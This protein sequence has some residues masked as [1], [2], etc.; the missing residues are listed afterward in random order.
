MDDAYLRERL[1]YQ[2]ERLAFA[3]K[4]GRPK[5]IARCLQRVRGLEALLA[6]RSETRR[7]AGLP[8]NKDRQPEA[9]TI[10]TIHDEENHG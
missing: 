6:A 3:E 10:H 2:R 8:A 5:H 9:V 4:L 1:D 7:R